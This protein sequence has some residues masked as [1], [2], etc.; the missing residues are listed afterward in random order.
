M[1]QQLPLVSIITVNY[2][3]AKVTTELLDSVR[4][5]SYPSVEIIVVDNASDQDPGPF[6]KEKYPEIKYIRSDENL[7]FSGGNN[8]G[9]QASTGDYLFFINNDAELTKGAIETLL[10]LFGAIPNL[11]IVSPLLCYYN[12]APDTHSDIIQYA[13]TTPVHPLTARNKTIGELQPDN[14]QFD[15]AVPTAY[16]HGAAMM[17]PRKVIEHVGLMPELF[18]LYYEELDW[19]EQIRR[20]GY[21]VYLEPRAKIYHKESVSVGKMSTLKT[22]YLNRNRILF[23]RRNR[24]G[25]QLAGFILFLLFCTI[26]KNALLHILKGELD[27]R[28]TFVRDIKWHTKNPDGRDEKP[29]FSQAPSLQDVS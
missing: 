25:W 15:R 29:S 21:A 1:E 9:I 8:L 16:A 10:N 13:G 23:I 20:E 7:G 24:S 18:F 27:H 22:H 14:G 26:P 4:V 19:S 11:G 2:N 3:Q 12:Q 17:V 5:N 6:L 28:M